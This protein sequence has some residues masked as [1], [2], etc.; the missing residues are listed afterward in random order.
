MF[1]RVRQE[2]LQI[3]AHQLVRHLPLRLTPLVLEVLPRGSTTEPSPA[4]GRDCPTCSL[5][6]RAVRVED[7][8]W[9]VP[10]IERSTMMTSIRTASVRAL[11]LSAAGLALLVGCSSDAD[12]VQQTPGVGGDAGTG[13]TAGNA[14]ADGG[15]IC[16]TTQ[17]Q[18]D[19]ACVSMDRD[20]FNCGACGH[21]CAKGEVCSA[22][23]CGLTCVGGTK[24]CGTACVDTDTDPAHCGDCGIACAS[25]EVCSAGTCGLTCVGGTKKCGTEC[26]DTDT[27][28]AHCGDCGI[29]C[30][31]G[32][33]CSAGTCGL[34]CVGG[35]KKC[36]T[37]CVDTDTDPAHCGDCGIVCASGEVCSAGTCGLTCV[38]STTKCGTACVDTDTDPAHCGNCGIACASGEVCSSGTCGL[39][40]LGGTMKCDT[41]CVDTDTDP[42]NCGDC[43]IACASGEVCSSGSCGL[44]CLGGTT[45]CGTACADTDTDPAHCGDC[46]IVCASGQVCS[47][48]TCGLTCVGGTKKCGTACV[49]TDT[50]PANCGDCDIACASGEV[51][52]SG[53]CGLTCVGGTIKCGTACV[54]TQT[55]PANCGDCDIA[56]AS[57]EICSEGTCGL[58]CVGGTIKCGTACV[59][60]QTDPA[61][62]G[63]CGIA[64]ASGEVCSSGTC[65]LTCVGGTLKCGTA[66]VDTQIDPA[67]CGD[68]DIACASG[69]ICS[70]GTC[71]LTCVGGT[72]KCGTGCVDTDI[73]PAHCGA[74]GHVCGE[75]ET[76]V[77]AV[78]HS[79][80]NAGELVCQGSCTNVSTS[81]SHCGACNHACAPTQ[82]C[83]AGVCVGKPNGYSVT[84]AWGAIWDGVARS[85]KPW[86]AAKADCEASGG[87]LPSVTE[88]WRNN[89]TTGLYSIAESTATSYLWTQIASYEAD[90]RRMNVRLS[91]GST[92]STP[93]VSSMAYRCVWMTNPASFTGANCLGAAGAG[94]SPLGWF[95]NV[96]T[97]DRPA[98]NLAAAVNDC[99]FHNGSLT[100]AR[101]IQELAQTG[102]PN[103][104]NN[105][106]WLSDREYWYSGNYGY[107][108]AR[109]ATNPQPHWT[110][111]SES[112][113]GTLAPASS[114][115]GF[116]CVGKRSESFGVLPSNPACNG[117]CFTSLRGKSRLTADSVDRTAATVATA[118]E[119]CRNLGAVLPDSGEFLDL[120]H[121][122]WPE[123]SNNWQW[124]GNTVYDGWSAG[125]ATSRWTGTGAENWVVDA[126]TSSYSGAATSYPYRCVWRERFSDSGLPSCASGEV[127]NWNGTAFLCAPAS[128]GDSGG[129]AVPNGVQFI[130]D[131]GNAWDSGERAPAT[132]AEAKS[133]CSAAGGRLPTATEVFRVRA[134]QSL[135]PSIGTS[136][137]YLW[138]ILPSDRAAQ[139]I[140]IRTSDGTTSLMTTTT[141]IAFR[142]IWPRT[143]GNVFDRSACYGEPSAPCFE[144]DRVRIDRYDRAPV[145]QPSAAFECALHGGRLLEHNDVLRV[146]HGGAPNG[147][148]GWLWT[149]E[150]NYWYNAGYG[151][152]IAA[153]TGTGIPAWAY[154]NSASPP[155]GN[156][157][158]NANFYR[159]RCMFSDELH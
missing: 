146:I 64:C 149:G 92:T 93:L 76:C 134:N 104:T 85:P 82:V 110:W 116:R 35:T 16:S 90:G 84:D 49:D 83:S 115:Y 77:N 107:D 105:W 10:G 26:V 66:C 12:T 130:D 71:G 80:C 145:P 154:Q 56:C 109:V 62:C 17:T 112:G 94:C 14:G 72:T 74:C 101:E 1:T 42:A 75:K 63:D 47:A 40:C 158:W 141:A 106:L 150:P 33:V 20:S 29:V 91:D 119:T 159:F 4:R 129:K 152:G 3:L 81:A 144:S 27:D 117:G 78:C 6:P 125:Y 55:D 73:D 9:F 126:T 19:G 53:T 114:S 138:T 79:T 98:M 25:G 96:D 131:W 30:A 22:G 8:V 137:T 11:V 122:G 127:P 120:V 86:V 69:E 133:L 103:P 31:S 57:G 5:P 28:P 111:S 108:L 18:C 148:G 124:T 128:A 97:R 118:S 32:E 135:V 102:M 44:T 121:A 139:G 36:G 142:C 113:Q 136:V 147:S 39:T 132:L 54:D 13:G 68:C 21:T 95:W 143:M 67:N 123:G 157:G 140:M 155:T 89:A 37:E 100:S 7:C 34:T 59:D 88:L 151:Y 87:R 156:V 46:G 50:D 70:S 61:N 60:T 38:G 99:S 15:I 45:K 48:G 41:A 43:D 52:S 58:T 153:W 24:K 23:T 65:G 2:R 51:C